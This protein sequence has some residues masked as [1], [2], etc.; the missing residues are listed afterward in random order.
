[1]SLGTLVKMRIAI[2]RKAREKRQEKERERRLS[3][4]VD[5]ERRP[6]NAAGLTAAAAEA[7]ASSIEY[8]AV[9]GETKRTSE[10]S[11]GGGG[12]SGG[13]SGSGSGSR[14]PPNVAGG[15]AAMGS[16]EA[17]YR[18]LRF[19]R[20]VGKV[21]IGRVSDQRAAHGSTPP[22]HPLLPCRC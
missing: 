5:T 10:S 9:D 14:T 20:A 11:A 22:H 16:D 1:M 17:I 3:A 13:A 15:S 21:L 18:K 4:I 8:H 12:G 7:L 6:S 19:Q 2:G